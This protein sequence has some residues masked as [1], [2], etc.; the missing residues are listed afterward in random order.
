MPCRDA[1]IANKE[2]I[3]GKETTIKGGRD[4]L[5]FFFHMW[6]KQQ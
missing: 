1:I 5:S 2:I 3:A 6:A 4:S